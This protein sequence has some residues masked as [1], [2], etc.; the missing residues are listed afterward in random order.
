MKSNDIAMT[1]VDEL[2]YLL[3]QIADLTAKANAIKDDL[4]DIATLPNG[5]KVFEGNLFKATF[6]ESNR[7]NVDYKAILKKYNVP[8]EV[9]AEFTKITP[10]FSI[11]TSAR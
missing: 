5:A 1:Q 10:V 6:S 7:T 11:T 9:V 4:K 3:A 2:G 8:A